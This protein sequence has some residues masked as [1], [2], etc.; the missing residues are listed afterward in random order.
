MSVGLFY[1]FTNIQYQ[2]VKKLQ[3]LA[4]EYQNV[5]RNAS[6]IVE[7]RDRLLV[8]YNT[9]PK[10]EI[11]RLNKVLPDHIDTVRLALDL[12]SIASRYGISIKS[13]QTSTGANAGSDLIV[14]PEN[15]VPYEKA[16][17]S[18]SFISNYDNFMSLLGDL[19]K[20]LRLMDIKSISFQTSE[21]GLY[22]YEIAVETYWLK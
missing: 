16:T 8:T 3:T 15:P 19:E 5:L 11:E 12:D 9:L 6:A 22:A 4:N 10:G 18:F 21:S 2:E 14:L 20:S 1:T 17:L 13:V 7:L